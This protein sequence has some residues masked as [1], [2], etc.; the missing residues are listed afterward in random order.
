MNREPPLKALLAFDAVMRSSSF[1]IAAEDLCV[2]PG[3]IGQQIRKLEDWLGTALFTRQVRQVLPT[4][5]AKAYWMRIQPAIVQILDASRA[6]RESR[7]NGVRVSMPPS[8]AAK[9]FTRR[10]A[11]FLTRHPEVE[12]HLGSSVMPV[13]FDRDAVDLAIRYF[14]G[15]DPRLEATLLLRDEARVYCSPSYAS[16]LKLK[17]AEDVTR[18]T[19]L[20]TTIQ[21]FWPQWLQRFSRLDAAAIETLPGIHFDQGLLAIEAAKQGQG[22]VMTSH[23]LTAEETAEGSL[24]E[25]F[26]HRLALNNSYFVVHPRHASLRPAAKQLKAWLIEEARMSQADKDA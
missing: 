12:L 5:E 4:P 21:P 20:H 18:A 2:T 7:N 14:N 13:D 8:F 10:M 16:R 23:H 19:L 9:W 26:R 15:Q 11:T 25:P 17:R 6:L 1:S 24:M 3:A 22:L